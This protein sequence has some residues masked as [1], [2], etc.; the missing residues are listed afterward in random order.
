[1]KYRTGLLLFSF[2]M[3]IM[4]NGCGKETPGNDAAEN[5]TGHT[6]ESE[7]EAMNDDETSYEV[8]DGTQYSVQE[9][10]SYDISE[11]E[12]PVYLND[13]SET[14]EMS[15]YFANGGSVPYVSV[16]DISFLMGFDEPEPIIY[17]VSYDDSGDHVIIT[18]GDTNYTADLDCTNE[19]ISFVDYDAFLKE[20]YVPLVDV[21]TPT[22]PCA[23]L[24]NQIDAL[25]N[26][27][28]GQEV[29][30]DLKPYGI[31]IIRD[32][33]GCYIPLQ[34]FSDLILS[35]KCAA[36]L[37]NGEAVFL[38]G[39][40]D[41]DLS[42]VYYKASPGVVEDDMALFAYN[43]LCLALDNLY[44][45]KGTHDI[46]SF[47]EFFNDVGLKDRLLS[48]DP[49][50]KDSAMYEM[51]T[52]YLDDLHSAFNDQ[53]YLT[54][55]DAYE[56]R[57][58][59]IYGNSSNDYQNYSSY[60][61]DERDAAY[62]NG[63]PAYEEVGNTA[64]ITFDE[65]TDPSNDTDYLSDPTEDELDDTIRLMQY[66]CDR[67]LR[68]GSPI[69]NVV[70]DLSVN[71]GGACSAASFVIGT[72]CGFGRMNI[73]NTLSGAR[74]ASVYAIDT[75]RDGEFDNEDT[76][77]DKGLNLYCLIS[78][79]SFSCGN[80]VPNEFKVDPGI[81]LLGMRSGGGSCIVQPLST[82]YGSFFQVSGARRMSMV[83]NGSF[84]DIDLGAEP[85][86]S[87]SKISDY[88]NRNRLTE[89]INSIY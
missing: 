52:L 87:I 63:I 5:E 18:R 8:T 57:I 9:N 77:S 1:M 71:C 89:F 27:R 42:E 62:P 35:Y 25:T 86:Y 13:V 28:Y 54:D 53:S 11:V 44:G 10:I 49:L 70:M 72:Y 76:L 30:F 84:Y 34:T 4:I 73:L 81:T 12:L 67:I 24:Y 88:Y 48:S 69:R 47:D 7:Y 29:S 79:C 66:S 80:L 37:Y 38:V 75:N 21:G 51:I 23:E 65:F 58:A 14:G 43:E 64:Y 50:E 31:D 60:F 33:D 16:N 83:K 20:E 39:E 68:E 82:A 40:M 19:T 56:K 41:D 22:G 6:G 36:A 45:L 15:I 55:P 3:A 78:P 74:T 59:E 2:V 61:T 85:D 26:D 32:G 46:T 17:D